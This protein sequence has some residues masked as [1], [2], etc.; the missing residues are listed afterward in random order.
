MIEREVARGSRIN[1]R[2]PFIRGKVRP[3]SSRRSSG[4]KRSE[5]W[6]RLHRTPFG[7]VMGGQSELPPSKTIISSLMSRIDTVGWKSDGRTISRS[8]RCCF[9]CFFFARRIRLRRTELGIASGKCPTA[10][11]WVRREQFDFLF[12]YTWNQ[13][14]V[15]KLTSREDE[16]GLRWGLFT[17]DLESAQQLDPL[18]AQVWVEGG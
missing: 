8:L 15:D 10:A 3:M 4:I 1:G 11:H 2:Q 9:S 13:A 12:E 6:R 14:C 7:G 5:T 17:G 18:K 16:R